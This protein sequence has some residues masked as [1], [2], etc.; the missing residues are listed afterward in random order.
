VLAIPYIGTIHAELG[1]ICISIAPEQTK[2]ASTANVF[3][4]SHM[5]LHIQPITEQRAMA[6]IFIGMIRLEKSTDCTKLA[7]TLIVAQ[8]TFVL[9]EN[10]LTL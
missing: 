9:K 10:V 7:L 2:F 6:V 4:N 1:R 5:F 8:Q 3:F